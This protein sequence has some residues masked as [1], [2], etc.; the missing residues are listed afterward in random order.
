MVQWRRK[1][2]DVIAGLRKGPTETHEQDNKDMGRKK[3][4]GVATVPTELPPKE[5]EPES[6]WSSSAPLTHGGTLYTLFP[7]KESSPPPPDVTPLPPT[8]MEEEGTEGVHRGWRQWWLPSAALDKTTEEGNQ[9]GHP[10]HT[11]TP[12]SSTTSP[13]TIVYP[14]STD[15]SSA[16]AVPSRTP[17]LFARPST[18]EKKPHDVAGEEEVAVR[19]P[20]TSRNA[21]PSSSLTPSYILPSA[22]VTERNGEQDEPFSVPLP[23]PS[24]PATSI[25]VGVPSTTSTAVSPP[26]LTLSHPAAA[27]PSSLLE[28]EHHTKNTQEPTQENGEKGNHSMDYSIDTRKEE[29]P[30]APP[31]TQAVDHTPPPSLPPSSS[32]PSLPAGGAGSHEAAKGS[33]TPPKEKKEQRKTT[34]IPNKARRKSIGTILPPLTSPFRWS[35]TEG[36]DAVHATEDAHYVSSSTN[37][38]VPSSTFTAVPT[39]RPKNTLQYSTLI[40]ELEQRRQKLLE[41]LEEASKKV[42]DMSI[43]AIVRSTSTTQLHQLLEAGLCN[44][45]ERD[46]N[47]CTPLHIA[48]SE[49]N[50]SIIHLLLSY[51][52]DLL[53]K[54]N[55]G[56]TPLDC[57]AANRQSIGRYLLTALREKKEAEARAARQSSSSGTASQ[58]PTEKGNNVVPVSSTPIA[59]TPHTSEKVERK[60]EPKVEVAAHTETASGRADKEARPCFSAND[61]VED[62]VKAGPPPTPPFV[63]DGGAAPLPPAVVVGPEEP[64]VQS[65]KDLNAPRPLPR[66][67]EEE[68]EKDSHRSTGATTPLLEVH[69]LPPTGNFHSALLNVMGE[70]SESNSFSGISSA[71][72][73]ARRES[74]TV[75]P[76]ALG[77]HSGGSSRRPSTITPET[78]EE[79]A[80]DALA[81]VSFSAAHEEEA[82][83]VAPSRRPTQAGEDPLSMPPPTPPPPLT[84]EEL[85]AAALNV[86]LVLAVDTQAGEKRVFS[87][88]Q[89]TWKREEGP[90]APFSFPG[91]PVALSINAEKEQ[92]ASPSAILQHTPLLTFFSQQG[93]GPAGVAP[94][95]SSSP[96]VSAPSSAWFTPAA[97]LMPRGSI[98][99]GAAEER[100]R[101]AAA[102][103]VAA[104]AAHHAS[105]GTS[106]ESMLCLSPSVAKGFVPMARTPLPSP[107]SSPTSAT[108]PSPT[109]H[110]EARGR[111]AT[112][113]SESMYHDKAIFPSSPRPPPASLPSSPTTES[114]HTTS[115]PPLVSPSSL[116][117]LVQQVEASD[118]NHSS[119]FFSFSRENSILGEAAVRIFME[120]VAAQEQQRR[121]KPAS[122]E[123]REFSVFST[124]NDHVP[125]MVCMC[126]LPGRGK[127]FISKRLVRYLNW[128]GVPCA[129]FNAG[130]YRRQLLGAGETAGASFFDP[131]N[132]VGKQ[133][134]ERMAELACQDLVKFVA[135]HQPLSVGI[136]DATNT[137]RVR[138]S[139]LASYFHEESKKHPRADGS[140]LSYRL[141]F[142]E[143]VCTDENIITENILRSKCD[144]DDFKDTLDP[145]KVIQEFRERIQQYEKVYEPLH[146]DE[147]FSFIKIINVKHHVVLHRVAGGLGS[148]IAFFL[149]NLHPVAFPV[150]IALPGET[151]GESRGEFGGDQRLTE[152]GMEYALSLRQFMEERFIPNMLVMHATSKSV[153][154]TLLPATV[155]TPNTAGS[156]AGG[157]YSSLPGGG[158][159]TG[160]HS[161]ATTLSSTN[162]HPIHRLEIGSPHLSACSSPSSEE[163]VEEGREPRR[164]E[165]EERIEEEVQEERPVR[166]PS[167]TRGG[168]SGE[169]AL[170][171]PLDT[172]NGEAEKGTSKGTGDGQAAACPI[173]AEVSPPVFPPLPTAGMPPSA[174]SIPTASAGMEANTNGR[175]WKGYRRDHRLPRSPTVPPS[176]VFL[177]TAAT[178]REG[179][180]AL[181]WPSVSECVHEPGRDRSEGAAGEPHVWHR[182]P[183]P[184]SITPP[185]SSTTATS[186]SFS[187]PSSATEQRRDFPHMAPPGLASSCS[188]PAPILAASGLTGGTPLPSYTTHS[189]S[190]AHRSSLQVRHAVH[191]AVLPAGTLASSPPSSCYPATSVA[192]HHP[193]T[194]TPSI[195]PP[196]VSGGGALPG[197]P[198]TTTT[199][200]GTNTGKYARSLT[201]WP[202]HYD[203][204]LL[205]KY[206][207]NQ[208]AVPLVVM[209]RHHHP[210][211][212]SG[213][214][215]FP[216]SSFGGHTPTPPPPFVTPSPTT[217]AASQQWE[218]EE[219]HGKRR[220]QPDPVTDHGRREKENEDLR[221]PA[222]F[223]ETR[224]GQAVGDTHYGLVPSSLSSVEHHPAREE[225]N[226]A[227]P[228]E[229]WPAA[230]LAGK[231]EKRD[232]DASGEAVRLTPLPHANDATATPE[233]KGTVRKQESN[234][235]EGPWNGVWPVA[236]GTRVEAASDAID[237]LTAA[238]SSDA[239]PLPSSS[240]F[241]PA[242]TRAS[243]RSS[244]SD[245]GPKETG[246]AHRLSSP[247]L[248]DG[249]GVLLPTTA[250]TLPGEVTGGDPQV[251]PGV[252]FLSSDAPEARRAAAL[253]TADERRLRSGQLH[254]APSASTTVVGVLPSSALLITGTARHPSV[255]AD[256]LQPGPMTA[257]PTSHCTSSSSSGVPRIE[258]T[259]PWTTTNTR[260]TA[261]SAA[262]RGSKRG[263]SPTGSAAHSPMAAP[264]FEGKDDDMENGEELD[265]V[266]CPVPGLDDI[267]YGKMNGR[268]PQWLHRQNER[269]ATMLFSSP[270]SVHSQEDPSSSPEAE[271]MRSAMHPSSTS[272]TDN[273]PSSRLPAPDATNVKRK[274]TSEE[275]TEDNEEEN[276]CQV[277][278]ADEKDGL[279]VEEGKQADA[280]SEHASHPIL[281]L[282]PVV[283]PSNYP[284]R[285]Q[286]ALRR[287]WKQFETYNAHA[288]HASSSAT[289]YYPSLNYTTAFPN[290]ESFRQVLSRLE[291]ALMAVMRSQT[292]VFVVSPLIPTQ[293]LLAFFLDIVPE[294]A[295]LLKVPKNSVLEIS[296]KG[297]VIVHPLPPPMENSSFIGFNE[298]E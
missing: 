241:G 97:S 95:P 12:Y 206:L 149:M 121:A 57:A 61:A 30:P 127:S 114:T 51:G 3:A 37:G 158:T 11:K 9:W 263:H 244:T 113:L 185:S 184:N 201:S 27:V 44:V 86:P 239:F 202:P 147:N 116:S 141:L 77:W 153:V 178:E 47:G 137:T 265:E 281:P 295:P 2:E 10:A 59:E 131:S 266:L 4:R 250:S 108:T 1:R 180:D 129:V 110:Q 19:R 232:E 262:Y 230:G 177:A 71:P 65:G 142:I 216:L 197:V 15:V 7:F 243:E 88:S 58:R 14:F 35:P 292:P 187:P 117:H 183:S 5:K 146:A 143:S 54:D 40:K 258:S 261:T 168:P 87:P 33:E 122:H 46:H 176:S 94:F 255:L 222:A 282:L 193:C 275:E 76:D 207:T 62:V 181:A 246:E 138:R 29:C 133:L 26:L 238:K 150:Y 85:L 164:H 120:H 98:L 229:A 162:S 99:P 236:S 175:N 125:L 103:A 296:V 106:R 267:N 210:L 134:R 45:N 298:S 90:L 221:P 132:P 167:A 119:R 288:P 226:R 96:S 92:L 22:H 100:Y 16:T 279:E 107:L 172:R 276:G 233:A 289:T 278:V 208:A 227:S 101:A 215:A 253:P 268:T 91:T 277:M 209:H 148:R 294:K 8:K 6:G 154:N 145:N 112:H 155:V 25:P 136:L 31:S 69:Q 124:V 83:A 245:G 79:E 63:L 72:A 205:E 286:A 247:P 144:N 280:V 38:I 93:K 192:S 55:Y 283:I 70:G 17:S 21:P 200:G 39:S 285:S 198:S 115:F 159:A 18:A 169:A 252:P 66:E 170:S 135:E 191:P 213:T 123:K 171:L 160:H 249:W 231:A 52:A 67:E 186:S 188:A 152:R 75:T 50:Q 84:A 13:S 89:D 287:C 111:N 157:G 273:E 74:S 256:S 163:D 161:F 82:K 196:A 272:E 248:Q 190:K 43:F 237:P 34:S 60:G 234:T 224:E 290:G 128:K 199:S 212:S 41:Q 151:V 156:A 32:S 109:L 166:Q 228:T 264:R 218:E 194:M 182:F 242:I 80:A 126:G 78:E 174:S 270:F 118:P 284:K 105:L 195:L 225:T 203:R 165:R 257:S 259:T 102:A 56:R 219:P 28:H 140:P 64:H 211:P 220:E 291:P 42:T 81:N 293:G 214:A 189:R 24:A 204:I 68:R 130:N 271:K 251:P 254:G 260:T 297:D 223:P 53:L 139:W 73:T 20:R 217:S 235:P 269:M 274:E 179:K 48:A 36:E 104:A 23:P 173:T 240:P 49:G